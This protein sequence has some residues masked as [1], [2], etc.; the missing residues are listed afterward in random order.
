VTLLE[1]TGP[2]RITADGC[3]VDLYAQ[4]PA[5]GEP[6]IIHAAVPA[7]ASI[8]DLGCGT[9]R[10]AHGLI[11]LGHEVVAVDQSAEMLE[12]VRGAESVCAPIAGLD[13]DR[14]FDAVL[15]ASHLANT[16]D[17]AERQ[18][19]LATGARHLAGDGRL[20]VQWHPPSW[21]D[22]VSDGPRG[23]LGAVGA[24]LVD[25]VRDSDLLS[26]TARYWT[27]TEMWTQPFTA[28]RFSEDG[29]RGELALAS[30]VFDEWLTED[31]TWFAATRDHQR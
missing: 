12:H 10:V 18:A 25:V 24:Q 3:A 17:D 19:L 2:G 8:L 15:L 7:G 31:H 4:L 30:L 1:P 6:E 23:M 11:A 13:L 14:Q 26:A 5:M 22:S 28:R 20:I 9:G 29:M 27:D 21:F 16:P